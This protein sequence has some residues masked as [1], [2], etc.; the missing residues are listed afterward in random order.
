MDRQPKHRR[1]FTAIN[2]L[3]VLLAVYLTN[4]L[5]PSA[6]PKEVSY[7]DFLA[8]LRGDHLTEVQISERELIGVVNAD[9][10][11]PKSCAELTIL[12]PCSLRISTRSLRSA[13]TIDKESRRILDGIYGRVTEILRKRRSE[14]TRISEALIRK[15]TLERAELDELLAKPEPATLAHQLQISN[16][17]AR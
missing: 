1:V 16:Q 11:Y 6:S 10:A 8:E 3:L 5:I 7:R 12:P 4:K 2:V 14:M 13:E 15:E 9:P 17:E